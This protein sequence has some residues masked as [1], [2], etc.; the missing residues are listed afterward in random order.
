MTKAKPELISAQLPTI[1]PPPAT[2]IM[3]D[4]ITIRTVGDEWKYPKRG[5]H[6]LKFLRFRDICT[7]AFV[8]GLK[9]ACHARLSQV[10]QKK[11]YKDLYN[12]FSYLNDFYK[13]NGERIDLLTDS[14]ILNFKS[15]QPNRFHELRGLLRNWAENGYHGLA[16]EVMDVMGLKHKL[17]YKTY[18]REAITTLDPKTGPLLELEAMLY[19]QA[20]SDLYAGGEISLERYCLGK[21]TLTFGARPVQWTL[22]KIKNLAVRQELDG[23]RSYVLFIPWAKQS[24]ELKPEPYDLTQSLGDALFAL[25]EQVRLRFPHDTLP[26]GF[27]WDDLPLFPYLSGNPPVPKSADCISHMIDKIAE[28]A[29]IVSPRPEAGSAPIKIGARRLRHTV[30]TRLATLG[31]YNARQIA[32]YLMQVNMQS[33]QCYVD[34]KEYLLENFNKYWEVRLEENAKLAL[35]IITEEEVD[36]T[37]GPHITFSED[38]KRRPKVGKCDKVGCKA[39]APL[40]CYGC[41]IFRPLLHAPHAEYLQILLDLR[42]RQ[43][44][45]APKNIGVFDKAMFEVRRVI[46][47]CEQIKSERGNDGKNTTV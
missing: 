20:L 43:L 41:A 32:N 39:R 23:G 25:T 4:G 26:E 28:M 12:I 3:K 31:E 18:S 37:V 33:A 29:N 15:Y 36:K 45:V 11:T 30:A 24:S 42:D 5:F 19:N 1:T 46:A 7:P 34:L 40:A 16:P 8:N 6:S 9:W 21:M 14:D 13:K 35:G 22:L 38:G 27:A 47:A 2:V 44:E 10:V 17:G